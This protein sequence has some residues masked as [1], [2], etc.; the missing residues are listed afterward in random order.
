MFL[1]SLCAVEL[2][3]VAIANGLFELLVPTMLGIATFWLVARI[4]PFETLRPSEGVAVMLLLRWVLSDC[5][6][7]ET[8]FE[9]VDLASCTLRW[10]AFFLCSSS[11]FFIIQFKCNFI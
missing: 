4:T 10:C 9:I 6:F 11:H 7:D 2:L 5:C 1:V 3:L 8:D